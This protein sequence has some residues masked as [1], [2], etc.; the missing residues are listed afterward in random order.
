MPSVASGPGRF[1]GRGIREG[2][3]CC[4]AVVVAGSGAAYATVTAVDSDIIM[5]VSINIFLSMFFILSCEECWI[6]CVKDKS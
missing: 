5:K 6:C 1:G 4:S 3:Y 2:L